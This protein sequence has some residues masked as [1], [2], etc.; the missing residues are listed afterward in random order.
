MLKDEIFIDTDTVVEQED[1]VA[2]RNKPMPNILH[3]NLQS[4]IVFQ[5]RLKYDSL[6]DFPTEV[7]LK[8]EPGATP[9]ILVYPKRA[10]FVRSDIKAKEA[11]MPLTTIEII[12]PSQ[13]I[14]VMAK[15]VREQ[16]FP[17][18]VKSAWIVVPAFKAVHV[19]LPGDNNLYF[20]KGDLHDPATNIELS[21]D[22]IFE[23]VV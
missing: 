10:S 2:E 16:Y 18:G 21:I 1:Y 11:E 3:G 15:K 9:D 7:S 12:S 23:R 22:K 4:D 19:M 20:D 6:Y 17:A 14:D 5:L 8:I 13:S